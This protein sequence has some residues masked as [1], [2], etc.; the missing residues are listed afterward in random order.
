MKKKLMLLGAGVL[1]FSLTACGVSGEKDYSGTYKGIYWKGHSKGVVLKDAKQKIETVLTLEKDGTISDAKID[2]LISKKGKWIARNNP[3]ATVSVDFSIDPIKATPGPEYKKGISMFDIKTNDKMGFYAVAVDDDGTVALAIVDAVIRYQFETKFKPGFDFNSKF[4]DLVIN[5][6]LIPTV[7]A[8]KSGLLKPKDWSKL[9]GK[10]L[11]AIH[12]FNNVIKKRGVLK[13]TDKNS[14]LIEVLTALGVDF[15]NGI[16]EKMDVKYGFHSNG[17]WN[18][19]YNAIAGYLIGKNVNELKSLIDW[20]PKRY[21]GA[22]NE[23][24]YFGIDITAGATKTVQNSFDGIAGSTV[25]MSRENTSY[26]DA[27]VKAGVLDEKDVIK[28]RF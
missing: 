26:M 10:N 7:K 2:F 17:G 4:E 27:L 16:P 14:T 18:G 11:Y 12:P 6:E 23:N 1:I 21:S 20:S 5:K 28:G 19:N 24:N 25:R 8:S 15:N 9:E 3:K 22:I 13:G